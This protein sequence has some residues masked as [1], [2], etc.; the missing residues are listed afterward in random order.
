[1]ANEPSRW[2]PIEKMIREF[3][4]L[5]VPTVPPLKIEK[6]VDCVSARKAASPLLKKGRSVSD[7]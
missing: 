7:L 5:F 6:G 2:V 3:Q 1:M 4:G